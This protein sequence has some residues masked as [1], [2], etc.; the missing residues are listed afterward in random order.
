MNVHAPFFVMS[1][2]CGVELG[3]A[4]V[5]AVECALISSIKVAGAFMFNLGIEIVMCSPFCVSPCVLLC[6]VETEVLAKSE[7]GQSS[8]ES[9][10][11]A[12]SSPANVEAANSARGK[13]TENLRRTINPSI[14][15][16]Y[17]N[18]ASQRNPG[19]GTPTFPAP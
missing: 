17:S 13:R 5:P 2:S 7:H 9:Q 3:S 14:N 12:P 11:A 1:M 16:C 10:G 6:S 15:H 4:V 8:G 18:S 19:G